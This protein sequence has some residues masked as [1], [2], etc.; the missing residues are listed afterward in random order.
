MPNEVYVNRKLKFSASA[1]VRPN[2]GGNMLT[3]R[4][5]SVD[6][7]DQYAIDTTYTYRDT[8]TGTSAAPT[9]GTG[10]LTLTTGTDDNAIGYLATGLR[11]DITYEPVLEAKVTINDISG[12]CFFFGFADAN[13]ES[14]P[15]ATIDYADGSAAAAATDACGFVVDGDSLS[16]S[17]AIIY[18][19]SIAT[20]GSVTATDTGEVWSDGEVKTLRVALDSDGN[21]RFYINGIEVHYQADAVTDVALCAMFNYGNRDGSSDTILVEYLAKFQDMP[22]DNT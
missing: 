2:V 14:T 9:V 3:E 1:E 22:S 13:T 18:A 21:A 11:F 17:D 15:N 10:G 12:S 19:A 6:W 20:G 4:M 5:C 8:S 16:G 7:F